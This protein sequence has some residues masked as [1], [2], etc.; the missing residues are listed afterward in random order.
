MV[1][2]PRLTPAAEQDLDEI[3]ADSIRL[4]GW[5][6][7]QQYAYA[8]LDSLNQIPQT[9]RAFPVTEIGE[10]EFRRKRHASHNIYVQV[11]DGDETL[12]LRILH[13]A[14]DPAGL[15]STTSAGSNP[16]STGQSASAGRQAMEAIFHAPASSTRT[17]VLIPAARLSPVSARTPS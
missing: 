1:N 10:R 9:P 15:I 17:S 4:F 5:F 3:V 2:R 16:A 7:A 13:A 12:I 8:L 14:R 6:Q 11:K